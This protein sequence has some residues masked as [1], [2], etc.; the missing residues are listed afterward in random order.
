MGDQIQYIDDI[1]TAIS[2]D[3]G[4]SFGGDNTE[5]GATSAPEK[6]STEAP[7]EVDVNAAQVKAEVSTTTRSSTTTTTT[8]STTTTTTEVP[9]T[10]ESTTEKAGSRLDDSDD[11][12]YT[13]KP[14]NKA[15]TEVLEDPEKGSSQFFS[16]L[17][18]W[19]SKYFT[20]L[21]FFICFIVIIVLV[22]KLKSA[23]QE[24]FLNVNGGNVSPGPGTDR[25]F[26]RETDHLTPSA[27]PQASFSFRDQQSLPR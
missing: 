7:S 25:C 3:L 24:G 8:T 27:R 6:D 11:D 1:L 21:G 16:Q 10:A 26:G 2:G 5:D 22:I 23:R 14:E 19:R 4:K 15:D 17:E 13:L 18:S 12:S 20:V 9:K